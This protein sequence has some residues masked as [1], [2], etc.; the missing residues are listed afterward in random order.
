MLESSNLRSSFSCRCS[1]WREVTSLINAK[2]GSLVVVIAFSGVII[3]LGFTS[4]FFFC[5]SGFT[6]VSLLGL[7]VLGAG[8]LVL[9]PLL[10]SLEGAELLSGNLGLASRLISSWYVVGRLSS[11]FGLGFRPLAVPLR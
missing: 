3:S 1:S 10:T 8:L 6:S 2:K 5:S 9:S 7:W 4:V 11:S